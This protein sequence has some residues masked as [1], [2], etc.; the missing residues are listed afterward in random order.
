MKERVSLILTASAKILS[1]SDSAEKSVHQYRVEPRIST[2]IC[3]LEWW[4]NHAGSDNRLA[5]P[6]T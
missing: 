6:A 4:S 3:P 1:C 2:E 5:T